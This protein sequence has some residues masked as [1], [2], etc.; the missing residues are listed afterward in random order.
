M[1]CIKCG[2]ENDDDAA[3][4]Q[5]C[6]NA[7]EGEE[8][9]RVAAKVRT[10]DRG[11]RNALAEPSAASLDAPGSHAR[12]DDADRIFSIAPTL[13]FV[14]AGYAAA[15]LAAFLLVALLAV[16]FPGLGTLIGVGLGILLLLIPAYFHLK[17]KLVR[18]TLRDTTIEIDR[19][20]IARTTQNV[21][22]R[23]IQDVTVSATL[24]QRL[25][26]YGD[27]T[28]D[29]ASEDGG[30]VVLDNVDSPKKYAD[31]ILKQMRLLDR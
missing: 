31:M 6:G 13:K 17:Q 3:F 19:G 30:K 12:L 26:G 15:V 23:R 27:V 24:F 21:P 10:A 28:I 22:L 2:K 8:E 9:T 11:L 4:C 7:F 5:K 14:L 29:N 20:L 1:F 16:F 18:Y 25:L